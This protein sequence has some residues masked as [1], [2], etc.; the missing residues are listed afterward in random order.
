MEQPVTIL[1]PP[2]KSLS[3]RFLIAAALAAGK[4]R[5]CNV[6]ESED[7]SRTMEVLVKAG[8]VID[9]QGPGVY[10][11][12]GNGGQIS[13]PA[14]GAPL[15]C[16]VGESGTTCRLMT[17]ILAAGRGCFRI[18]GGA[19]LESRPI[20][21]LSAA[22]G[23]LGAEINFE[24]TPGYPPFTL[25][26]RGLSA[27]DI[28]SGMVDIG[29][30]ESSQYLSGLLMAAPLGRGLTIRLG[31]ERVM[32]W[33]Y[34]GLT[35][36]TLERFGIDFQAEVVRE[37][38]WEGIPWREIG[39]ARP[40]MLRFTV[41]SGMYRPGEFAIEGDYSAASYFFA[42][43]AIGPRP[44]TVTGLDAGSLQGDRVFLDVLEQM[45][46]KVSRGPDRITVFPGPLKG[47]TVD[48][49]QCPDLVPTLA[50]TAAHARGQTVIR[51]AGHLSIKEC[52]RLQSPARELIK[53]GC[54]VEATSSGLK[55]S[56]PIRHLGP[57]DENTV[58]SAHNDHRMAMS[59]A[60]L[61]L[62]DKNGNQGFDVKIDNPGC[63]SKSFPEFWN[64]WKRITDF[65]NGV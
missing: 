19:S 33:P 23:V 6:L 27:V 28:P 45:G 55:I 51:N 7:I 63:V 18:Q 59:L 15:V 50:M 5:L 4:S 13:G 57:L 25:K 47:V 3:H 62:P 26:A 36:M 11:V 21:E 9:R 35:L 40:F 37:S 29:C 34:I 58:F 43:G 39:D 49:G 30:D 46:A 14:G 10:A 1:A 20:L 32:S 52:D 8:A 2:S 24:R 60:L 65:K 56:P 64:L 38:K 22:L 44:V 16:F 61:G 12:T 48:V 53:A 31:G 41:N 42:A 17:S 54:A